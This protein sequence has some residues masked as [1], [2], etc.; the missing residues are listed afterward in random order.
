VGGPADKRTG[1][2]TD[3]RAAGRAG[4]GALVKEGVVGMDGVR[5]IEQMVDDL[6]R[7][8]GLTW[9]ADERADALRE[10]AALVPHVD[11]MWEIPSPDPVDGWRE[12]ES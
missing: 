4:G 3:L 2:T 5:D 11:R 10:A 9:T 6:V 1:G 7:A 12:A 8:L